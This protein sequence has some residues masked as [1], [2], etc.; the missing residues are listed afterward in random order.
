MQRK[1]WRRSLRQNGRL[2]IAALILLDVGAYFGVVRPL[3]DRALATYQRYNRLR[4]SLV[5]QREKV[6]QL[7]TLAK[8][9]DEAGLQLE[10]FYRDNFY[11]RGDTFSRLSNLLRRT[12]AGAGVELDEINYQVGES[13]EN[14]VQYISVRTATVADWAALMRFLHR[15]ERAQALILIDDVSIGPST[16]PGLLRLQ[17]NLKA[18][19]RPQNELEHPQ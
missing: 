4:R 5:R 7:A 17:V 2:L 9:L 8:R 15:L 6:Q 1:N 12:A 13:E 3:R 19:L 16:F 14:S 10:D 18:Y 11:T